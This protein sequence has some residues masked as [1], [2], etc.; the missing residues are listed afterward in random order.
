LKIRDNRKPARAKASEFDE[1]LRA[2]FELAD[3]SGQATLKHFRKP[4]AVE[5]KA[6]AGHFDPVTKADRGAERAILRKL[7]AIFPD[8]GVVGEEYGSKPGSS[9][10]TWVIDPIDGTRSFIIGSPLWG[11]LIGVLKDGEPLLGLV[12]QPFTGE[13]VWSDNKATFS[14]AAGKKRKLKTRPCPRLQD[15]ILTTTHPDLFEGDTRKGV[16]AAIKDAARMTRYGGDCYGYCLLASGWVD[17]IIESGLK[18]YDIVAL[19]PIVERAGGKITTWDGKPAT[20]GGDIVA[21]GDARLH[22]A[23]LKR[24]ARL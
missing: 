14:A 6:G 7:K 22:D 16:F 2:A 10:Y 18:P 21:S 15:A 3:L 8:H 24:I 19:I 4:V 1:I 11:T 23:V 12:D 5:N 9:P 20:D 17:V 13:R